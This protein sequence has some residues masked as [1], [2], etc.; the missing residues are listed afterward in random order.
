[1]VDGTG[2]FEKN[3]GKKEKEKNLLEKNCGDKNGIEAYEWKWRV[4]KS[5]ERC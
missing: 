2:R 4:V 1:V 3:G 5:E